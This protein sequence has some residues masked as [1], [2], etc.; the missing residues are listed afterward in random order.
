MNVKVRSQK[1][2]PQ[3]V[4]WIMLVIRRNGK[5]RARKG[6]L[7]RGT[8][9]LSGPTRPPGLGLIANFNNLEVIRRWPPRKVLEGRRR[10]SHLNQGGITRGFCGQEP[11]V[12]TPWT[13]AP[14]ATSGELGCPSRLPPGY[15]KDGGRHIHPRTC[16]ERR[17]HHDVVGQR[18]RGGRCGPTGH[19]DPGPDGAVCAVV[20]TGGPGITNDGRRT[21]RRQSSQARQRPKE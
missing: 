13:S 4:K 2:K 10:R 17:D 16:Q 9:T 1:L 8:P 15:L 12:G 21:Y 5:R 18:I 7:L 20:T 14:H 19:S 3:H 11:G 6:S